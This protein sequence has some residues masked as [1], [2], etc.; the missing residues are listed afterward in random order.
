VDPVTT[1]VKPDSQPGWRGLRRA[2]LIVGVLLAVGV[3]AT[4][5]VRANLDG[6]V[7]R[8]I[9]HYGSA[10]TQVSV[11]VGGVQIDATNGRGKITGLVVGNP[12]GFKTPHAFK[13]ENIEVVI[14]VATLTHDVIVVKR[15][16]VLAPD[17]MY[18][19]GDKHTNFEALQKNIAQSLG[20][21]QSSPAGK[22]RKLI[23]ED[24]SIRKAH[25]Q[26]SAAFLDGKTVD[27]NLPDI[28]LYNIG[29]AQGGVTPA[30]LGQIIGKAVVQRLVVAFSWDKL[31]KSVGD[32]LEKAGN[33]IKNLFN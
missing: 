8:A 2:G 33:A 11:K 26:G 16:M 4:L 32:G 20:E 19:Q 22:P 28:E 18:E 13:V 12:R 30:E 14:D 21:S 6:L 27:V 17:V 31:K 25:A 9:V 23:I 7:Q 29:K 24:F 10:M 5:W 3:A 15:I 1:L